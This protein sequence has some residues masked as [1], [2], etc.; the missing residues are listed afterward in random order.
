ML[1]ALLACRDPAARQDALAALRSIARDQP[2]AFG[3]VGL[4]QLIAFVQD[5]ALAA[6]ALALLDTLSEGP[7]PPLSGERLREAAVASLTATRGGWSLSHSVRLAGKAVGA[8]LLPCSSEIVRHALAAQDRIVERFSSPLPPG[9]ERSVPPDVATALV[10]LLDSCGQEV[11]SACKQ[12]LASGDEGDEEDGVA[13]LAVLLLEAQ[14]AALS[15]QFAGQILAAARSIPAPYPQY[16]EPRLEGLLAGLRRCVRADPL[17]VGRLTLEA[18]RDWNPDTRWLV[19]ATLIELDVSD[20]SHAIVPDLLAFVADPSLDPEVRC[21]VASE[22]R[23]VARARPSLT[24]GHLPL[25]VECYLT[26]TAEML[27]VRQRAPVDG[28]FLDTARHHSQETTLTAC[29]VSPAEAVAAAEAW[30]ASSSE[31]ERALALRMLGA[32]VRSDRAL[33]ATALPWLMAALGDSSSF[34]MLNAVRAF[35]L[36]VERPHLALPAEVTSRLVEVLE[37]V[38]LEAGGIICR[39]LVNLEAG[40]SPEA[41]RILT[42]T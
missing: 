9:A 35:E 41:R 31:V 12:L 11:V 38:D 18:L 2:D 7:F 15:V 34:V 16:N 25:F 5:A 1:E 4:S 24:S 27:D 8:G 21:E 42:W 10:A 13:G 39:V 30:F 36:L 14:G 29:R 32:A 23:A 22:V 26:I 20:V 3:A 6:S 37:T 17:A 19:A 33:I 40:R 28:D